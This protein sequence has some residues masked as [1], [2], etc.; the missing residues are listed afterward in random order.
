M[1]HNYDHFHHRLSCM[2]M[3]LAVWSGHGLVSEGT[4]SDTGSLVSSWPSDCSFNVDDEH[5]QNNVASSAHP[6]ADHRPHS[7]CYQSRLLLFQLNW[8]SIA[9][10]CCEKGLHCL[11][12][13]I[14]ISTRTAVW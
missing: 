4:S 12:V 6:T 11:L 8:L 13:R 14:A 2:E 5:N 9:R 3:S 7:P 1:L 10:A